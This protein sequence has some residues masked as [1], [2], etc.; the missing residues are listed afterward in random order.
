LEGSSHSLLFSRRN[1]TFDEIYTFSG[2]V[3]DSGACLLPPAPPQSRRIEFI[4]DSFTAAESNEAAEQQLPWEARFPVTNIDQ[5]FAAVIARR[6]RAQHTTTCRSGSGMVCD[7]QGKRG[8]SLPARFDRALMDSSEPKWDFRR[9]VPEV[10]VICLGLNDHAGLRDSAGE[11]SGKNSALF[12]KTYHEFL[13][14][15]RRLYPA[16]AV[17]AVAAF[18]EWI[19]KNVRQV[20]NEEKG[21]GIRNIFYAEFDEFPGGYVA[22][23]HPTVETHRKMADQLI[24]AM[25]SFHLFPK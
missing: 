2:I 1:I 6:F 24:A 4:G 16:A 23:G 14:T 17:V 18:P 21:A 20:V 11:V 15:L 12:R 19:R 9:W 22:N 8:E 13:S 3:L 25:E 7:W 10:V 5:G